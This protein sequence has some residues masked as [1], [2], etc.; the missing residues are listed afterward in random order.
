[1]NGFEMVP[2]SFMTS[3][4]TT[5]TLQLQMRR[6]LA[7]STRHFCPSD[8]T[9]EDDTWGDKVDE[10]DNPE[11]VDIVSSLSTIACYKKLLQRKSQ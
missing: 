8:Y 4:S 9:H 10:K 2:R 5:S 6:L 1:M 11:Y 3:D 7:L